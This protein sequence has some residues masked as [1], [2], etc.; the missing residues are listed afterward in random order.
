MLPLSA[1]SQ[2]QVLQPSTMQLSDLGCGRATGYAEGRANAISGVIT[3][4]QIFYAG[5]TGGGV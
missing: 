3:N 1:W 5:Y 4:D 2:G